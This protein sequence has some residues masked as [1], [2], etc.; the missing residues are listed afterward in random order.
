MLHL[1][2]FSQKR[3][4]FTNWYRNQPSM[5]RDEDCLGFNYYNKGAWSDEDCDQLRS[6]ICQHLGKLGF[7]CLLCYS[8]NEVIIHLNGI[9]FSFI[10]LLEVNWGNELGELIRW[11]AA[12]GAIMDMD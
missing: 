12:R 10:S 4:G 2:I 5:K 3:F 6:F 8:G 11:I 7:K 1:L 9:F